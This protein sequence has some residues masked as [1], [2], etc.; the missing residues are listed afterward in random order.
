MKREKKAKAKLFSPK[1]LIYDFVKATAA[2]PGL[3]IFRPKW[4]YESEKAKERIRGG[5]LA[6]SNHYGFF[7]PLYL[8]IAIWYR[9]HRFVCG[10]E[11]FESRARFWFK[12]FLCIPIDRANFNI[13]S[14]RAITDAMKSGYLVSMF[15][16]GHVNGERT[17]DLEDF[18]PGLVLMALQAKAPVIPVYIKPRKR[19]YERIRFAVG[20][21][22]DVTSFY[23]ERPTFAQI[24]EIARAVREK[25]EYLKSLV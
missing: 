16:E 12:S 10:K 24:G 7:D 8:M 17:G 5:A 23:G 15:P 9:R 1:Y 3:L 22:I 20:E 19:F 13:S 14:L 2:L 25:E 4:I 11:F 18:K 21:P 6:V